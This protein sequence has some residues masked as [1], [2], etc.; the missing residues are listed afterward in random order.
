VVSDRTARQVNGMLTA[1]VQAGTGQSASIPG[2]SVAGKTGTARRPS[3]TSRGY[4]QGAYIATF[5]GMVP[6][7]NPQLSVIVVIDKPQGSYYASQ[8]AAP[9]FA[10]IAQYGLRLFRI[11]PPPAAAPPGN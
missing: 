8:I 6:A 4:E 9:V 11:P 7:E 5:A 3:E 1:V 2:Y 10:Q